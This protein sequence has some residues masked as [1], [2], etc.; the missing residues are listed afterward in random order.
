MLVR[1]R[2]GL[3]YLW[4]SSAIFLSLVYTCLSLCLGHFASALSNLFSSTCFLVLFISFCLFDFTFQHP[5]TSWNV[6]PWIP[7]DIQKVHIGYFVFSF[8]LLMFNLWLHTFVEC[9]LTC[10][11]AMT[12]THRVHFIYCCLFK[13]KIIRIYPCLR[14]LQK[15]TLVIL[16]KCWWWVW[17]LG[18]NSNPEVNLILSEK[19]YKNIVCWSGEPKLV[20]NL[21]KVVTNICWC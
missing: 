18:G 13:S 12:C 3:F 5:S 11:L 10:T 21:R 9:R 4:V 7:F 8:R 1:Q 19:G 14:L 16:Y 20:A 15:Y 17:K 6:E 2:F